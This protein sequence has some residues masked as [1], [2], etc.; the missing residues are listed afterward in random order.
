[1]REPYLVEGMCIHT[2]HLGADDFRP[3]RVVAFH[4]R[5]MDRSYSMTWDCDDELSP[6]ENAI[7]AVTQLIENWD[8]KEYNPGLGIKA[9]GW[10]H[11]H[12]YFILGEG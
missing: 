5:D 2:K 6:A 3:R 8:M 10:D 4:K 1:M 7:A 12:Y 11:D 9:M